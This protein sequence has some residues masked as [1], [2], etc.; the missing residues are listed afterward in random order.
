MEKVT[1]FLFDW[2]F[3]ELNLSK[4]KLK[5]FSDNYKA[6]SLYERCGMLTVGNIP[7]KRVNTKDGWKWEETKLDSTNEFGERYFSI[8]EI[9][10][11]S[12]FA[13]K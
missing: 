8:M 7:L 11:D 13:K 12:Y 6:I 10:R 2:M 9:R 5:V 4:V 1:R 3:K